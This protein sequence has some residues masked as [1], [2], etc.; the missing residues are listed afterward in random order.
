MPRRVVQD[1]IKSG[2]VQ[3]NGQKEHHPGHRIREGVHITLTWVAAPL[4]ESPPL[5]PPIDI[6]FEDDWIM[7]INK[8]AGWLSH[9]VNG[10]NLAS[11]SEWAVGYHPPIQQ[12]G[13]PHRPGIVHRLDQY[14][15]GLMIVAKNP[16][17]LTACQALFKSRQIQKTYWA[18]VTGNV[19]SDTLDINQPI[20]RSTKKQNRMVVHPDGKVALSRLEVVT[21]YGS[22]TLVKMTPLTGRTHQIRVHLQFIGHPVVGDPL[23]GVNAHPHGQLLQAGGLSFIHPLTHEPL[24]FYLPLS[25]RLHR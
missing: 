16:A 25:N 10:R 5:P 24:S 15:E 2:G 3:I 12:V 4:G 17:A 21:R 19:L 9:P 18:L 8:P 23:Y 14:T 22:M 1:A 6:V 7:V 11:V 20:L 13:H